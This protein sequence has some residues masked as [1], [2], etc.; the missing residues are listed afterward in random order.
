MANALGKVCAGCGVE[1]KKKGMILYRTTDFMPFCRD[2]YFC[3]DEHPNSPKN[4]LANQGL[5][6]LIS[7][8]EAQESFRKWLD[9]NHADPVK[10]KKIRQMV[11]RPITIRIGSPELAETLLS[12]QDEFNMSSLSDAMRYCIQSVRENRGHYYSDH[13]VLKEEKQQEENYQKAAVIEPV[14]E[15]TE[16]IKETEKPQPV[17]LPASDW[18]F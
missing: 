12:I 3:N 14:K 11:D 15:V 8:E 1:R 5:T 16:E 2:F 6:E 13:K 17:T 18:E 9:V 4:V 7:F 10:V